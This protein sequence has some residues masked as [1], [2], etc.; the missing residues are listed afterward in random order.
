MA[1]TKKGWSGYALNDTIPNRWSFIA[2]ISNFS[3]EAVTISK[4][5]TNGAVF[6][7]F[8]EL[9][10]ENLKIRLWDKINKIF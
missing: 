1:W 9:P 2:A 8:L 5:N 4:N 6:V 7:E 3:F 10:I